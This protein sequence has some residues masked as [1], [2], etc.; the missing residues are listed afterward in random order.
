VLAAYESRLQ[1]W[2]EANEIYGRER[3]LGPWRIGD[4]VELS[5][6]LAEWLERDSPGTLR[7]EDEER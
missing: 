2:R 7:A 1:S 4:R 6:S 3:H 5:E